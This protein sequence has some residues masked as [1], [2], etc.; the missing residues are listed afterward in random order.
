ME[1]IVVELTLRLEN[2]LSPKI[3][4]ETNKTLLIDTLDS[5]DRFSIVNLQRCQFNILACF[6]TYISYEVKSNFISL[7]LINKVE[8]SK[9]QNCEKK[10]EVEC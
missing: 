9:L 8:V 1:E 7:N 10:A 4:I 2:K 6:D 5:F 3:K